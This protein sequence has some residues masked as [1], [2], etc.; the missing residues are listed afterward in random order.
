[1]NDIFKKLIDNGRKDALDS[2]DTFKKVAKEFGYTEEEIEN[3]LHDF[4]ISDDDLV[5]VAGGYDGLEDYVNRPRPSKQ[6]ST[7]HDGH[8]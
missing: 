8:N 4:P 6:G 1:M 2:V 7:I 3:A 5:G